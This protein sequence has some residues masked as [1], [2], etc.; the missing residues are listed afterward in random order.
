MAELPRAQHRSVIAWAQ[1]RRTMF[2][3]RTPRN[4]EAKAALSLSVY[5]LPMWICHF[6]QAFFAFTLYWC[7]KLGRHCMPVMEINSMMKNIYFFYTFYNPVMY[8]V[9]SREF[10]RA[11][12]RLYKRRMRMDTNHILH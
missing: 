4:L 8:A 7:L 3:A 5:V 9:T 11:F 2:A 6:P 10:R 1:F 12:A